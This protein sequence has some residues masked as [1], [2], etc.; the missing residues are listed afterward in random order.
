MKGVNVLLL[1]LVLDGCAITENTI[2]YGSNEV[3]RFLLAAEGG[4][5]TILWCLMNF[6]AVFARDRL[7]MNQRNH[8]GLS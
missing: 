2:R 6:P 3:W 5:R 8:M 1:S 4:S 7:W